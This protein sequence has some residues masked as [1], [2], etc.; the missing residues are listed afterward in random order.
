M[1]VAPYLSRGKKVGL[2]LRVGEL[3][4]LLGDH[5][6]LGARLVHMGGRHRPRG[7][8][9]LDPGGTAGQIGP[10]LVVRLEAEDDILR[11]HP[12]HSYSEQ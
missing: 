1:S 7:V 3:Q 4:L 10:A 2:A 8:A 12:T 11:R 5:H 6:D 9:G